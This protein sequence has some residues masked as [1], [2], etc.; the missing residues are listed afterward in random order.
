V[1]DA[2]SYADA[3]R[4][5]GE[6]FLAWAADTPSDDP[7]TWDVD[8]SLAAPHFASGSVVHLIPESD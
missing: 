6:H 1:I 4:Q 8:A 2:E 5:I 3:L 7:D